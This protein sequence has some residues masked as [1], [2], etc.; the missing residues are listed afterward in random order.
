MHPS[1]AIVQSCDKYAWRCRRLMT[2][3]RWRTSYVTLTIPVAIADIDNFIAMKDMFY[4]D[5]KDTVATVGIND[6]FGI[7]E[8]IW[9]KCH[10]KWPHESDQAPTSWGGAT[11]REQKR[12]IGYHMN[13]LLCYFSCPHLDNMNRAIRRVSSWLLANRKREMGLLLTLSKLCVY[14]CQSRFS[15]QTI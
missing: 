4:V 12:K 13:P 7:E 1:I 14:A 6:I 2:C 10:G 9:I 3:L 5:I 15:R 8:A 11:L